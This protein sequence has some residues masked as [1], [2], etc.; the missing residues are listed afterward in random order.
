MA[1]DTPNMTKPAALISSN[2]TGRR[3]EAMAAGGSAS[4]EGSY[5]GK[6][7]SSGNGSGLEPL[8][9]NSGMSI[10]SASISTGLSSQHPNISDTVRWNESSIVFCDG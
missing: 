9:L 6:D 4:G 10:A 2:D 5:A 1:V 8:S 7:L 3:E